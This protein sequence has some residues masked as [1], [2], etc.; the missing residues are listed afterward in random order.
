M[1]LTGVSAG[2]DR[3]SRRGLRPS[4]VRHRPSQRP[5]PRPRIRTAGPLPQRIDRAIESVRG[6][7]EVAL[8]EVPDRIGVA[9]QADLDV[10]RVLA[11]RERGRA[12][13]VHRNLVAEPRVGHRLE[14]QAHRQRRKAPPSGGVLAPAGGDQ[15]EVG[16]APLV[17]HRR[18]LE[19]DHRGERERSHLVRRSPCFGEAFRGETL[20]QVDRAELLQ[21]ADTPQRQTGV[22]GDAVRLLERGLGGLRVVHPLCSTD[23]LE[24]FALH[25]GL[26]GC[27]PLR[28]GEL[29]D[30]ERSCPV[31]SA[32]RGEGRDRRGPG[33]S[34]L[35]FENERRD[36]AGVILGHRPLAGGERSSRDLEVDVGSLSR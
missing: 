17:V 5:E 18:Q 7:T 2:S 9:P 8:R 23:H 15:R 13:R 24:G 28:E 16:F 35:V 22:G 33:L 34:R 25:N 11:G 31:V 10:H 19:I 20:E 3:T 30:R 26:E 4:F 1:R 32:H 27:S 21:C 14:G 12:R 36:R 6:G 29:G